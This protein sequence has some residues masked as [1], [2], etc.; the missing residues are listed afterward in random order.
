MAT[1]LTPAQ[2]KV[3][4]KPF[5]ERAMDFAFDNELESLQAEFHAAHQ[6][7]V[8]PLPLESDVKGQNGLL[9]EAACG[10][11]VDVCKFLLHQ[12]ADPNAVGE[13]NRTPLARA[14]NNDAVAVVPLLLEA[15]ADP[16]LLFAQELEPPSEEYPEGRKL[17]RPWDTDDIAGLRCGAPI[18]KLLAEWDISVTLRKLAEHAVAKQRQRQ[19]QREADEQREMNAAER[20]ADAEAQ[21]A[22]ARDARR[23]A[24]QAR[25][26]RIKEY[27]TLKCEKQGTEEAFALLDRLIKQSTDEE[28]VARLTVEALEREVRQLGKDFRTAAAEVHGHEWDMEIPLGQIEDVVLE[29]VGGVIAASGKTALVVDANGQAASFLSYRPLTMLE[30]GNSHHMSSGQLLV[31]VLS[32]LRYGK[33][34]VINCGAID[35][36]EAFSRVAAGLDAVRPGLTLEVTRGTVA[37]AYRPLLTDDLVKENPSLEPKNFTSVTMERFRFAF[38]TKDVT[39]LDPELGG[40]FYTV[41]V[42]PPAGV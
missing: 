19:A 31:S 4:R 7:G 13:H 15:G 23:T 2:K 6:K 11:A 30:A 12:G 32:A 9:S 3:M 33:P 5:V 35:L 25:E 14:L 29:D 40:H 41:F 17:F 10:G 28:V 20:L 24:F 18:K 22:E 8:G 38:V 34:L 39:P 37:Q 42:A 27:D 36:S 1:S 16:R 21:L 26:R